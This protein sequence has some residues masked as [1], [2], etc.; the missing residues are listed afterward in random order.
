MPKKWR[1]QAPPAPPPAHISIAREKTDPAACLDLLSHPH[2]PSQPVGYFR[3][4]IM[5]PGVARTELWPSLPSRA[6]VISARPISATARLPRRDSTFCWKH[7]A[8]TAERVLNLFTSK[9]SVV[10]HGYVREENQRK[11]TLQPFSL[12]GPCMAA[13]CFYSHATTSH[14]ACEKQLVSQTETESMP[15]VDLFAWIIRNEHL[16]GALLKFTTINLSDLSCCVGTRLCT[17]YSPE[18]CG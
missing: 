12:R 14:Q 8:E 11:F 13:I 7:M 15:G 9:S 17:A 1:T 18:K 5:M 16:Q 6:H 2:D 10:W 3:M 4:S